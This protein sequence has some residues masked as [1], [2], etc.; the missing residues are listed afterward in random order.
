MTMR[1]GLKDVLS[2]LAFC[3]EIV[4]KSDGHFHNF[5]LYISP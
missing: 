5:S 2:K 1:P 3:D 4:I